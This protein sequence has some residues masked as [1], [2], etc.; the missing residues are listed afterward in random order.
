MKKMNVGRI[1]CFIPFKQSTALFWYFTGVDMIANRCLKWHFVR[2][3]ATGEQ[4]AATQQT[5]A[6][7][8]LL[9]LL[10]CFTHK[11]PT[12]SGRSHV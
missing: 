1:S 4:A 7:L 6:L 10:P 2:V 5:A 3:S 8:H 12:Q 9:A 11:P